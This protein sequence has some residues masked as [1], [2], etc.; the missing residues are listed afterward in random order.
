[1]KRLMPAVV[2]LSLLFSLYAAWVRSVIEVN[3]PQ[4]YAEALNYNGA[5]SQS[6]PRHFVLYGQSPREEPYQTK[7]RKELRPTEHFT[8]WGKWNYDK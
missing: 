2:V 1:M 8:L 3:K 4:T 5:V 6:A 7:T